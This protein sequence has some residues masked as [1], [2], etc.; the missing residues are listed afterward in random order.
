[1]PA[2]ISQDRGRSRIDGSRRIVAG[3]DASPRSSTSVTR[4]N[5]K[6]GGVGEPGSGV[7]SACSGIARFPELGGRRGALH[8]VQPDY[9]GDRVQQR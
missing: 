7:E 2:L 5:G 9:P 6:R 1:M 4:G 8:I 3:S